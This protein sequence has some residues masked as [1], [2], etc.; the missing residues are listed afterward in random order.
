M[1]E[2]VAMK[3]YVREA[4][5]TAM[6][7]IGLLPASGAAHDA[8]VAP[9]RQLAVALPLRAPPAGVRDLKFGEMFAAPVGPRGLEPSAT[10]REL[11]GKRV[12]L[13]GYVVSGAAATA[14]GFLLSPLPVVADDEDEALADDIPPSAVLVRVSGLAHALPPV[15]GL[16][17]LS[18]TL[19]L[20]A[21]LDAATG[22]VS[23]A[24]LEPDRST[25]QA[26]RRLARSPRR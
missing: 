11:D 12:R 4:A 25:A 5:M 16:V 15:R 18:G 10:L 8:P 19:H 24:W 17:R 7:L 21:A 3:R 9:P 23:T 14:D 26:L 2:S 1:Q 22:R 20:G 6:L 13:I